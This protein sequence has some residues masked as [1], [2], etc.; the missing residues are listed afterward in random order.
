MKNKIIK[1]TF[2]AVLLLCWNLS[3]AQM[4]GQTVELEIKISET[5]FSQVSQQPGQSLNPL[6]WLANNSMI[7]F[8]GIEQ[9]QT[10]QAGNNQPI[11]TT[12]RPRLMEDNN[13]PEGYQINIYTVNHRGN[14]TGHES[15]PVELDVNQAP[16]N[17]IINTNQFSNT[18]ED[19]FSNENF[20]P[21]KAVNMTGGTLRNQQDARR[22]AGSVGVQAINQI[23]PGDQV[24]STDGELSAIVVMLTPDSQ[25]FKNP[26]SSSSAIFV[27]RTS[28]RM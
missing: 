4:G 1:I 16:L 25:Q 17:Q 24:L 28:S 10:P 2:A 27:G 19:L 22:A 6:Q 20:E 11:S 7:E 9:D 12:N 3:Y 5:D 21:Q 13:E 8:D 18:I 23:Q 15:M 26:V 14:V